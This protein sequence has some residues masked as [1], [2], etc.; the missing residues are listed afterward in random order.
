MPPVPSFA[1]EHAVDGAAAEAFAAAAMPTT[2]EE[3]WRYSRIDDL[4]LGRFRPAPR[5]A[6]GAEQPAPAT[7]VLDLAS[8]AGSYGLVTVGGRLTS[9][10]VLGGPRDGV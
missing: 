9:T 7:S 10:V 6:E 8:G 3:V 4:D 1:P 5:E 2:D